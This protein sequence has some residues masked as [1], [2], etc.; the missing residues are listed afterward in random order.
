MS[1]EIID[2]FLNFNDA[3]IEVWEWIFN[4]IPHLTEHVILYMMGLKL[5]CVSKKAPDDDLEW[6]KLA[7][8]AWYRPQSSCPIKGWF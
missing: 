5:N 6:C 8:E 1:N 3:T 2:P 4:I 7:H